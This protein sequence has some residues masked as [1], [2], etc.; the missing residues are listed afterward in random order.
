MIHARSLTP[1]DRPRIAA[2][3]ATLDA[4]TADE[5][6]VAL[7]LVDARLARPELD[8]YRFILSTDESTGRLAGYLCY[9]KTPMTRSTYDLYW[10]ATNAEFARSGIARGLLTSLEADLAMQGGGTLRVE[11]GSREGHGAAVRFYD[12]TGFSRAGLIEDFYAPGDDLIIY[13]KRVSGELAPPVVDIGEAGLIDAAFG[14]RDYANERDFLLTCGAR[15]RRAG[16]TPRARV[17]LRHRASSLG[18]RGRWRGGRRRRRLR[19]PA[20]LCSAAARHA[21]LHAEHH[22][23]AGPPR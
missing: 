20:R 8:D 11:T 14:Y 13:A 6:A 4:F 16:P 17:G 9:G 10:I 23:R 15:A 3:L 2:L 18:L 21:G 1:E 12:A 7:E 19:E 22:V 5:Q